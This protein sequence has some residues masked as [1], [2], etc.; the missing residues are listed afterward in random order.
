MLICLIIGVC[1][2]IISFPQI[3]ADVSADL[4]GFAAA[5]TLHLWIIGA[6]ILVIFFPQ[7]SADVSADLKRIC[8]SDNITSLDY[9]CLDIG[10]LIIHSF[11]HSKFTHSNLLFSLPLPAKE[12]Y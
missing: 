9:W 7:I 10:Y 12:R 8:S 1:I 6:C 4:R 11:S 5:I 2:L 3:C